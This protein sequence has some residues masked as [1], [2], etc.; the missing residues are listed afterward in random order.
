[1]TMGSFHLIWIL[2]ILINL[3]TLTNQSFHHKPYN[4][5]LGIWKTRLPPHHQEDPVALE[6]FPYSVPYAVFVLQRWLKPGMWSSAAVIQQRS[7]GPTTS[8][9]NR[10]QSIK[11]AVFYSGNSQLA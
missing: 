5:S 8:Q 2:F 10:D 1:M 6:V 11:V 9:G 7:Q 4:L 3:T